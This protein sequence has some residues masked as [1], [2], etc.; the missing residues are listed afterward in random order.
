MQSQYKIFLR[1]WH[2]RAAVLVAIPFTVILVTGI[3]LQLRNRVAWVSPPP[4]TGSPGNPRLSPNELIAIAQGIAGAQVKDWRDIDRIEIRPKQGITTIRTHNH[5]ELQIDSQK[6]EVLSAGIR[7][8]G[9]VLAIHEGNWFHP[10]APL[11]IFLP[12]G[13]ILI[14]VVFSGLWIFGSTW[15]RA[16]PRKTA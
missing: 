15:S 7:Q 14:W 16:K 1:R 10:L 5:W 9:L 3:L 2:R 11:W 6:G 8:A 4:P 12:T 13:I